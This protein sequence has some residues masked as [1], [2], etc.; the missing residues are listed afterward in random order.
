MKSDE[1]LIA[2]Y[3]EGDESPLEILVERYAGY[4]FNFIH[5]YVRD[6]NS[7][8][9]LTQEVF[10]KVWKNIRKF[11][12]DRNF[13]VWIF[14]IA[15]NTVFD[16]LRKRKE[17][18]F[19]QFEKEDEI[20]DIADSDPLPSEIFDR[21][22]IREKV[23]EATQALS[24]KYQEVITLYYQNQLNFREIAEVTGE[25]IDTIKSRHRRAIALLKR[26]LS[27]NEPK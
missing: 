5:K 15:R 16:F 22:N 17:I 12:P 18:N 1:K 19:S 3:L 4:V 9:D 11:D 23:Q 20:Y 8:Q 13:K 14:Q 10:I 7:A 25:P 21:K 26:S 2:E 24:E 6:I 27:K